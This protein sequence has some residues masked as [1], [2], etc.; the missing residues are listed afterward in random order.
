MLVQ[1]LLG[2]LWGDRIWN[3]PPEASS[4]LSTLFAIVAGKFLV[5]FRDGTRACLLMAALPVEFLAFFILLDVSRDKPIQRDG[6]N[7]NE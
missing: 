1:E 3:V 6:H 2:V 7:K 5:T 4:D